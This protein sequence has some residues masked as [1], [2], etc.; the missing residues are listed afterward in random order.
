VRFIN[1]KKVPPDPIEPRHDSSLFTKSREVTTCFFLNPR[2]EDVLV[3]ECVTT[4]N[5][6]GSDY[7]LLL[8]CHPPQY[9]HLYVLNCL[10]PVSLSDILCAAVA[11]AS[12]SLSYM[13]L[14]D[15]EHVCG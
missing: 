12:C 1:D 9:R 15:T 2:I 8:R 10:G 14:P 4:L 13:R 6:Y 7:S 11:F 5:D 3:A